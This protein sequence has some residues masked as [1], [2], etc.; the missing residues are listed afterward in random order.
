MIIFGEKKIIGNGHPVLY[1]I[2]NPYPL[3]Q[4][5]FT[6]KYNIHQVVLS[7]KTWCPLSVSD[8]TNVDIVFPCFDLIS[9]ITLDYLLEFISFKGTATWT[10]KNKYYLLLQ[11]AVFVEH[12]HDSVVVKLCT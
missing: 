12:Y 4:N 6:H 9:L 5:E 1:T 3:K 7:R 2:D 8:T 11:I 10:M